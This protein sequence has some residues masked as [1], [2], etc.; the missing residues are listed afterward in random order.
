MSGLDMSDEEHDVALSD[1]SPW[2]EQARTPKEYARHPTLPK[3]VAAGLLTR[4]R[5][6]GCRSEVSPPSD[7]VRDAAAGAHLGPGRRA[8]GRHPLVRKRPLPR[9]S[10]IRSGMF[11][12]CGWLENVLFELVAGLHPQLAE[13][14]A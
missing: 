3:K 6:Q 7:A 1:G 11:G 13:R 4:L 12:A 8:L 14:L 2:L 5:E 9:G 10:V